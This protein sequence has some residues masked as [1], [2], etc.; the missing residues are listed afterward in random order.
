MF[1]LDRDG[2]LLGHMATPTTNMPSNTALLG[3]WADMV[4]GV[5]GGIALATDGGGDNF[6]KGDLSIRAILPVDFAVRHAASFVKN[7]AP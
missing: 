7:V 6:A 3:N 5:W 2:R 1:G 4:M